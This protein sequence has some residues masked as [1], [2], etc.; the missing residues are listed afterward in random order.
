MS[1]TAVGRLNKAFGVK[2][3]IKV[4]PQKPFIEDLKNSS[5][6][7]IQKGRD[8]IPFFV[9]SIEDEPHFLVKFEDVD[10][11]ESAKD[12]TGC[13]ILLRDQ[14][15]TIKTN[16]TENDLDKLVNFSVEHAGEVI[17]VIDRIE[18]FPQQTMA[19]IHRDSREIMMPLT[20]EFILQIDLDEKRIIVDLPGGFVES[21][22]GD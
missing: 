4:V 19:F 9:E 15:I 7:F 11:P 10:N 1:Q 22:L 21:Q 16:D 6:W 20:P 3:H 14:D 2:G 8:S 18:E 12:I 5:V 17:G 13:T